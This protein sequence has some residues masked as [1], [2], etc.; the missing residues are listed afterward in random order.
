MQ[1][2]ELGL[3]K[4]SFLFFYRRVFVTLT[5][6]N[7]AM[8]LLNLSMILIMLVWC[9]GFF[10]AYLF[11]C[12]TDFYAYYGRNQVFEKQHCVQTTML[13]TAFASSDVIADFIILVMPIA[14]ASPSRWPAF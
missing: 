1:I 9:I 11:V 4:L 6:K 14:R 12:G 10:F 13:N 2:L 5:T 8:G 3:V 7:G